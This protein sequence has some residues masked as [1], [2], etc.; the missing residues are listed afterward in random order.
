MLVAEREQV[1][2]ISSPSLV[3]LGCK[4]KRLSLVEW[5]RKI[6]CQNACTLVHKLSTSAHPHVQLRA[7]S[8]ALDWHFGTCVPLAESIP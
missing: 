8:V 6:L 5:S 4:A 3:L 7:D 2:P 1:H